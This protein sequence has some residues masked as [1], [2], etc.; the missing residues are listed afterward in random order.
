MNKT[1]KVAWFNLAMALLGIAIGVWVI[2]EL[3]VLGRL[4]EGFA[5]V[6]PLIA[7]WLAV[8]IAIISLRR[9]QS[10][11]EVESDERDDLIKKRAVLTSFVSVWIWNNG[12]SLGERW[13]R[14]SVRSLS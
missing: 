9:K 4:P 6:W 7:I 5:M 10:A 11:S 13:G 3:V 8:V 1:Q 12:G 2:V 14:G